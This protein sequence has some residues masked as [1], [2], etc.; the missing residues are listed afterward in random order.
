[1]REDT[2]IGVLLGLSPLHLVHLPIDPSLFQRGLDTTVEQ[3]SVD[4]LTIDV[5]KLEVLCNESLPECHHGGIV[6]AIR[7]R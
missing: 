3:P 2:V 6:E 7:V 1:M 5:L 4:V